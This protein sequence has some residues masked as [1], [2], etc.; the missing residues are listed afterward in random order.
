MP[1]T[2]DPK[3]LIT[4]I[5]FFGDAQT[6]KTDSDY[7]SAFATAKLLGEAGYT[8]VNGGGPGIM[9]AS[10]Q[11][12]ESVGGQTTAVTFAPK[13]AGS[14]EGRYLKNLSQVDREV[15][16]SNYIERMFGLIEES[17]AFVVFRGG[18]GTLSE[19]GTVWV[20]ANI[21]FGHHK[22]FL[23]FGSQWW[24]IVSV[25][26]TNMNIDPQEMK[27]FKIVESKEEVLQALEQFE[28]EFSQIDHSHCK[29]CGE[30]AVML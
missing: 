8:I 25:L 3:R 1:Q 13:F 11:G 14:F 2:L 28:W 10:T 12:A 27:C 5:A 6:P 17:D 4:R 20:L 21:Y 26:K 30:N 7:Q 22:P 18:S 29:V 23:L 19:F 24:E 15:I 9:D 16:A